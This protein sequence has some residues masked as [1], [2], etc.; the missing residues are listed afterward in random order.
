MRGSVKRRVTYRIGDHTTFRDNKTNNVNGLSH[1][2]MVKRGEP[3]GYF[4]KRS[5]GFAIGTAVNKSS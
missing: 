1:G 3:V 5:R 4:Y 2:Y